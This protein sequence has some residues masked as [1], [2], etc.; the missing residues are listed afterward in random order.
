MFINVF[1]QEVSSRIPALELGLAFLPVGAAAKS[2]D[3]AQAQP[4]ALDCEGG[5]NAWGHLGEPVAVDWIHI[6]ADELPTAS[7]TAEPEI[8]GCVI[9][10]GD[11]AVAV[12]WIK[13]LAD[14]FLNP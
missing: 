14:E 11:P 7:I 13:I 6:L 5:G 9:D 3:S 4:L 1:N 12:D 2:G 10:L 8:G